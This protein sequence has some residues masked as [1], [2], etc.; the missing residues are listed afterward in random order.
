MASKA[1]EIT[2]EY[3]MSEQFLVDAAEKKVDINVKLSNKTALMF[4]IEKLSVGVKSNN[5]YERVKKL[6]E[7]GSDL[8]ARNNHKQAAIHYA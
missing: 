8:E 7:L 6:I 2:L 1:S 4:A 3:M 5:T